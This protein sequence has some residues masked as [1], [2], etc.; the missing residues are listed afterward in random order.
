MRQ[1]IAEVA[2]SL[3]SPPNRIDIYATDPARNMPIVAAFRAGFGKNRTNPRDFFAVDA[4]LRKKLVRQLQIRWV[5]RAAR[6]PLRYFNAAAKR[7]A[8]AK[9]GEAWLRQIRVA[10]SRA[11]PGR[12]PDLTEP[13]KK[14]KRREHGGIYPIGVASGE[15]FR[16]LHVRIA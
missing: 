16:S 7:E 2:R 11:T 15:L 5:R 13:Y 4:A 14:R 1:K 8:M 12:W 9:T 10:V 3:S 6:D